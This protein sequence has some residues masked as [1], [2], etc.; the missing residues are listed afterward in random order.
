MYI[1]FIDSTEIYNINKKR[2]EVSVITRYSDVPNAYD[3][4]IINIILY[5]SPA[6]KNYT[7]HSPKKLI[8]PLTNNVYRHGPRRPKF[9]SCFLPHCTRT[10]VPLVVSL[11]G[12]VLQT[13]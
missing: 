10:T 7:R 8:L 4:K 13:I 6:H 11:V 9:C 12:L 2:K 5:V 1:F 3:D